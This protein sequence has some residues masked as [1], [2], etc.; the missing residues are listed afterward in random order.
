MAFHFIETMKSI[1]KLKENY[2]FRRAYKKGKSF[3]SPFLIIYATKNRRGE[4]RLGITAGK[5]IGGAVQRNRAKRVITAAIRSCIENVQSGYD[6]IVVARSRILNEKST[7]VAE[8]LKRQFKAA[9]IWCESQNE[10]A[11]N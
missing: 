1:S 11:V 6:V 3:V 5:K 8:V 2:E 4:T 10:Q 7:S 9:G